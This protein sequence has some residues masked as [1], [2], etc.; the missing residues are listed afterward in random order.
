MFDDPFVKYA[1]LVKVLDHPIAGKIKVVG[2]PVKYSY[3]ENR[4]RSPPPILGQHTIQ[5]LKSVLNYSDEK[6]DGLVGKHIVD[7]YK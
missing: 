1:E 4:A 2:P 3:A 5:V 6:I 7:F